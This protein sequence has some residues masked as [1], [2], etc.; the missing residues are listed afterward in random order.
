MPTQLTFKGD[1]KSSKSKKRK[2]PSSSLDTPEDASLVAVTTIS[3]A[4]GKDAPT[5]SLAI[6]DDD[7]WVSVDAPTDLAGPVILVLPLDPPACIASDANGTVFAMEVENMVDKNP[8]TSEPHDV[9]QVWVAT[10]IAGL[11][12]GVVSLKGGHGR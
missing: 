7:S 12:E 10:R 3:N 1:K 11:G 4:T 9:R 8:D 5:A 6:E 2:A